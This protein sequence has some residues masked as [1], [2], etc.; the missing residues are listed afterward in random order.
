MSSATRET[1]MLIMSLNVEIRCPAVEV[2]AMPVDAGLSGAK[3]MSAV[4]AKDRAETCERVADVR[5]AACARGATFHTP[6]SARHL[7]GAR[8]PRQSERGSGWSLHRK[9]D[10]VMMVRSMD[11]P[12]LAWSQAPPS[13]T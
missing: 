10:T 6:R 5:M 3:D 8:S 1:R 9:S 4:S 12:T 7:S 2:D 11:T 13:G